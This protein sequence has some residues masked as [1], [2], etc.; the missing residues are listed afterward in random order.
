MGFL[1]LNITAELLLIR[2]VKSDFELH[3]GLQ[4]VI[5]EARV[6]FRLYV[7]HVRENLLRQ[8]CRSKD[9][10]DSKSILFH[11]HL[12]ATCQIKVCQL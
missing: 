6:V 3:A 1:F 5:S 12:R 7:V 9:G 4:A 11:V 2:A 8:V 10:Q